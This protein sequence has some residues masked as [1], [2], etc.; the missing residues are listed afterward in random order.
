MVIRLITVFALLS[1]LFSVAGGQTNEN[2]LN[3]YLVIPEPEGCGFSWAYEDAFYD[4][5]RA[6]T[7]MSLLQLKTGLYQA[8]LKNDE[9]LAAR[10]ELDLASVY[11]FL[12]SAQV[13]KQYTNEALKA[14]KQK[15]DF[16]PTAEGAYLIGCAYGQ[17]DQ[18]DTADRWYERAINL[19]DD[20]YPAY[21]EIVSG[22]SSVTDTALK[23]WVER[24][25]AL[26]E[27]L[28]N[29][30]CD[31]SLRAD[32]AYRYAQMKRQIILTNQALGLLDL[33][34]DVFTNLLTNQGRIQLDSVK[35][36]SLALSWILKVT[37]GLCAPEVIE[38]FSTA[39]TLD[40]GKTH[41]QLTY[42]SSELARIFIPAFYELMTKGDETSQSPLIL[43]RQ[44][45]DRTRDDV[46]PI[47][48]RLDKI[49]YTEK[50]RYPSVYYY[51]A[52]ADL[53]IG[54]YWH[55]YQEIKTFNLLVPDNTCGYGLYCGI[56]V[57]FE[58][59]NSEEAAGL[60]DELV[61]ITQQKCDQYP[62]GPDCY[63][64]GV[65]L[66]YDGNLSAA[67]PALESAIMLDGENPRPRI[68]LAICTYLLGDN[69]KSEALV[70]LLQQQESKLSSND[71]ACYSILRA[72]QNARQ[73]EI[74]SA[75]YWAQK[76]VDSEA[77][78]P[79][80]D[81]LL[82]ILKSMR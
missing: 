31:S 40:P 59:V 27:R 65:L 3:E 79:K 51:L 69:K 30:D 16:S 35:I 81:S 19:E 25:A 71:L 29:S 57:S 24:T 36:D 18:S 52:I 54:D 72:V 33:F 23:P 47:R 44:S 77:K 12:D 5:L 26:A 68:S 22:I 8:K 82:N 55:A 62:S 41:Y 42:L 60:G 1:V 80:A 48:D 64:A 67:V 7:N 13:A 63:L 78:I 10:I 38:L 4:S 14:L 6:N 46:L 39:A 17:S 43:M 53:M 56:V 2:A 75:I 21:F 9:L 37:G 61:R 49:P 28:I 70:R 50:L 73:G 58:A 76:A 11:S 20:Y 66:I 34:T 32:V 45:L 74:E 15:Y